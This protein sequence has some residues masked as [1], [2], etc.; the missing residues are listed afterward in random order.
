M[1]K[2]RTVCGII[3]AAMLFAS[4][5]LHPVQA[6]NNSTFTIMMYLCGTDLETDSAAASLDIIEIAESSLVSGGAVRYIV[7]TGG[8]KE[9]WIDDIDPTRNQRW[10]IEDGDMTLLTT[11]KRKNMGDS[12]TLADFIQYTTQSYPADRCALIVWDHGGGAISGVCSDEYT[13]DTLSLKEVHDALAKADAA[14]GFGALEFVCFDA[15]LMGSLETALAVSDYSNYLIA[16]EELVPGSGLEYTT[17]LNA[18]CDAP[19]M[20]AEALA[21]TIIDAFV[22]SALDN[23]PDDYITMSAIDLSKIAALAAELDSVGSDLLSMMD[24][25][26]SLISRD[27]AGLRSFGSYSGS[28]SS[29]MVDLAQFAGVYGGLSG[30]D[31]SGLL[32]ALDDAVLYSRASQNV[33]KACGLSILM[34]LA[35]RDESQ[36][37]MPEYD[38]SGLLPVYTAFIAD[39]ADMMNGGSYVFSAPQV[40]TGFGLFASLFSSSQPAPSSPSIGGLIGSISGQSAAPPIEPANDDLFYFTQLDA[41]QMAYLA[42][43]EGNL[44]L[45]LSDDDGEYYIDLGYLRDVRIDWAEGLVVSMFDGSWPQLEG[46]L[47]NMSDQIVTDKTRRSLIDVTVNGNEVYLLA[48]FDDARPDG[49][50]IGYTQGYDANGNPTR[51][52]EKLKPG[53][54]IVPMYDLLYW[55]DDD[56]M[57]YERFEGDPITFSGKRL[58]FGYENLIGSEL[59]CVYAFCLNDVFGDY[60]FSEFLSFVL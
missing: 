17:W 13:R 44:M 41:E 49:E 30:V 29:D 36:T 31:T 24:G 25:K 11:S 39:F 47:V 42:Y 28:D 26:F 5:S 52:Y 37:Y 54:I 18:L 43:A 45:D 10:L 50:I 21:K 22:K 27:R 19:D 20:P 33:G 3:A 38:V 46:Q 53:D 35:T 32:N 58:D 48:Q 4:I 60:Q 59:D 34:P 1:R 6:Q 7:E 9:W 40:Q 2:R 8:T 56:E 14:V 15:C 12:D 23:D 51:G 16:S 57:Q 55:D